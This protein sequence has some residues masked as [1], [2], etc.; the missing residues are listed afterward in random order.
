MPD[1]RPAAGDTGALAALGLADPV[2]V[3]SADPFREPVY[4]DGQSWPDQD[5]D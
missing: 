3:P 5:E 4:A 2:P 1:P